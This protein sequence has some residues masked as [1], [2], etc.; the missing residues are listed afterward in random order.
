MKNKKKAIGQVNKTCSDDD[1]WVE[2]TD[3]DED[4]P[5]SIVCPTSKGRTNIS[6]DGKTQQRKNSKTSRAKTRKHGQN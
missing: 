6:I 1:G 3:S 5:V 4:V 2:E